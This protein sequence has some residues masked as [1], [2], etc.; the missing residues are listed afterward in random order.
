MM[1][2]LN[3]VEYTA[4]CNSKRGTVFCFSGST[5]V[6]SSCIAKSDSM[7]FRFK[8][9]ISTNCCCWKRSITKNMQI[10]WVIH[11]KGM[12][13]GNFKLLELGQFIDPIF[14]FFTKCCPLLQNCVRTILIRMVSGAAKPRVSNSWETMLRSFLWVN[15]DES[16]FEM[17]R[18]GAK[19]SVSVRIWHCIPKTRCKL[20][21]VNNSSTGLHSTVGSIWSQTRIELLHHF[22][23]LNSP[24][25]N[26]NCS[27]FW[28]AFASCSE[29]KE[30]TNCPYNSSFEL[31][32]KHPD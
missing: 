20:S 3:R 24:R 28:I 19:A 32:S 12:L 11:T 17:L 15:E 26:V 29:S 5:L 18:G 14:D 1:V 21:F 10:N 30:A 13:S 23:N 7:F 25:A 22:T 9:K 31:A 16:V 4:A 27:C 6:I 8:N 2:F